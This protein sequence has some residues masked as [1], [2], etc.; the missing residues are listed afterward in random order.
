MS[1]LFSFNSHELLITYNEYSPVISRPMHTSNQL[2]C[3]KGKRPKSHS[4]THIHPVSTRC[5]L[6]VFDESSNLKFSE[7][8]K[9]FKADNN[10]NIVW[11]VYCGAQWVIPSQL[12][13]RGWE[14]ACVVSRA[15]SLRAACLHSANDNLYSLAPGHSGRPVTP[16]LISIHKWLPTSNITDTQRLIWGQPPSLTSLWFSWNSPWTPARMVFGSSCRIS[17]KQTSSMAPTQ[18]LHHKANQV[19]L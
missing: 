4:N 1:M 8:M 5:H 11:W 9:W 12:A 14:Q 15:A 13:G 7:L 10:A 19:V 3:P 2:T 18:R 17:S 16:H 6:Q